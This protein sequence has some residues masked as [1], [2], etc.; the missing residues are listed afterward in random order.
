MTTAHELLGH[1][2]MY[3]KTRD[4]L[5]ASHT[6]DWEGEI[7]YDTELNCTVIEFTRIPNNHVLE[8][9]IEEV[10]KQSLYN[11]ENNK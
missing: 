3:E 11:Y 2:Y 6:H 1:G 5:K 4:Y 7:S 10:V 8:Q 9:L